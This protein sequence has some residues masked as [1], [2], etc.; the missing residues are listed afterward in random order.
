MEQPTVRAWLETQGIADGQAATVLLEKCEGNFLYLRHAFDA[1][2]NNQKLTF[3]DLQRL[4]PGLES[5]Y[6]SYLNRQF[7]THRDAQGNTRATGFDAPRRLL[8]VLVAARE[9]LNAEQLQ[10]PRVW[11]ATTDCL[12]CFVS[13]MA[14]CNQKIRTD[15]AFSTCLSPSG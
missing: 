15:T 12:R 13:S 10:N 7:Q 9:P 3:A 1:I 5:L 2:E 14:M 11:I 8:E 4:P 6:H